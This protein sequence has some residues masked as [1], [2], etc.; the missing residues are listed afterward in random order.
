MTNS[1]IEDKVVPFKDIFKAQ[2]LK[3]QLDEIAAK[4]YAVSVPRCV[5]DSERNWM[6]SDGLP[7]SPCNPPY[8]YPLYYKRAEKIGIPE[9]GIAEI[10]GSI[11]SVISNVEKA[12]ELADDRAKYFFDNRDE[13]MSK[14]NK[15]RSKLYKTASW[16][17]T[18]GENYSEYVESVNSQLDNIE[19]V[20]QQEANGLRSYKNNAISIIKSTRDGNPL[21]KSVPEIAK[22][23]IKNAKKVHQFLKRLADENLGKKF[24]VK[25]PKSCNINYSDKMQYYPDFT[26][27]MAT[28]PFGFKP[29]PVDTDA[30]YVNS[31]YFDLELSF[32]RAALPLNPFFT[33]HEHYND[34][35]KLKEAYTAINPK[36]LQSYQAKK[37]YTYGA[38]KCNWNTVG[39]K[40]DF[41]Y[42]P[43]PQGGFFNYAL[44][45]QNMSLSESL[46]IQDSP[47]ELPS[48][49]EQGL[50]PVDLTNIMVSSNRVSPYVRF[51]NSQYYDFSQIPPD[52]FTQQ[53]RDKYNNR[54]FVPDVSETLDN[55]QPDK[56]DFLNES[57]NDIT[58]QDS[59][60]SRLN[61]KPESVAFVKC[62]VN[63]EFYLTPPIATAKT[64]IWANDYEVSFAIES[65]SIVQFEDSS[66][67]L[68]TAEIGPN[69]IPIFKVSSDGV[70][71]KSIWNFPT[72]TLTEEFNTTLKSPAVVSVLTKYGASWK[73]KSITR[74]PSQSLGEGF[75]DVVLERATGVAYLS[76]TPLPQA[77]LAAGSPT[78]VKNDLVTFGRRYD[79]HL[80]SWM[81][82]TEKKLLDPDNVYALI[83]LPGKVIPIA[84]KRFCDSVLQSYEPVKFKNVMTQ[85]VIRI[86]DFVDPAPKINKQKDISCYSSAFNTLTKDINYENVTSAQK[87]QQKILRGLSLAKNKINFT[88]PS[89]VYP[90]IVA[91]PLMS[92]ERCYGPWQ[93]ASIVNPESDPRERY[94]DIGGK[95]EFIKDENLAPWN[96]AGYQLMNEAGSL[97]AQLSNSLLLFSER[98]GFVFADYPSGIGL[99]K[100]LLNEGPLV[101]SITV[102]VSNNGLRTTVKM[103]LY[104]S[105]FGK[106]Q[107]QKEM[108]ISQVARER[109]KIIDRNNAAIRRGLGKGQANMDLYGSVLKNGGQNLLRLA[110]SDPEEYSTLQ[111]GKLG[112]KITIMENNIDQTTGE[113]VKN[114]IDIH[115]DDFNELKQ[116][117][118]NNND[119]RRI[120]MQHYIVEN[121]GE[122]T[123]YI[124][125]GPI[126]TTNPKTVEAAG[127]I[128]L[129]VGWSIPH[130]DPQNRQYVISAVQ[131]HIG[132]FL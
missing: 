39:E 131:D 2:K 109:Q 47:G 132:T 42:K 128:E 107:K 75:E 116:L 69:I 23:H 113:F 78:K 11:N 112:Q 105:R 129:G 18:G 5:W 119:I 99:A 86:N 43:E 106:M 54:L 66:G 3:D 100:H 26:Q 10:Q 110:K 80:D 19:K 55:I 79:R 56:K 74:S 91:L 6:G 83:S 4:N 21:T 102:D 17:E 88:A 92:M 53:F 87:E 15:I 8:G 85:D 89:P 65:P 35:Y 25:V 29:M 61:R 124:L 14:I 44:Y 31:A 64:H 7:A 95:V 115:P 90:D 114:N 63:E 120:D 101:T 103:D 49:V 16:Q 93:S 123:E 104:T 84:E 9:A 28:G 60:N 125:N 81:V 24:L 20:W 118:P 122:I 70:N 77:E 117:F 34:Y 108:A 36:T 32:L 1:I 51:D 62:N 72:S 40:W 22:K 50:V 126:G 45:N 71:G 94:F 30:S 96:Y 97:Q 48:A 76:G 127:E 33:F 82:I 46:H 41:N 130:N 57:F 12:E 13:A 58:S 98:G 67:C 111:R 38:L 52:S 73:L 59:M 37:S 121:K 68:G 27:N